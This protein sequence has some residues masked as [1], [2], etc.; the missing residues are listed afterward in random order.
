MPERQVSETGDVVRFAGPTGLPVVVNKESKSKAKTRI[1]YADPKDQQSFK[2]H[3]QL[4]THLSKRQT[5]KNM[6]SLMFIEL[7][8]K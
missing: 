1:N 8:K 7:I 6:L 5:N 2:S 4:K 3:K